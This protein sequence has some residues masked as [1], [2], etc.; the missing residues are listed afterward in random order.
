MSHEHLKY[1]LD[2]TKMQIEKVFEGFPEADLDAKLHDGA[3]SPRETLE[4]L[5]EC[6]QAVLT[7]TEGGKH[8]W[9]SFSIADKSFA[10]LLKQRDA[11]RAQAVEA[12]LNEDDEHAAMYGFNYIALH[13]A[14]H[15]GQIVQL[16]LKLN[17]D[18]NA[19]E[20]YG[21]E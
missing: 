3:M 9:G 21:S 17:P 5:C 19:Y 6:Y 11:M 13:D 2:Q 18:W 15:V 20:I 8:D 4:H 16:R 1:A 7:D 12:A 10:N 14:Y